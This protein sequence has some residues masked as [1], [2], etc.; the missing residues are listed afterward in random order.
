MSNRA[1]IAVALCAASLLAGCGDGS[2]G[3]TP[4]AS[5]PAPRPSA[6]AATARARPLLYVW[7]NFEET[8]VPDEVTVYADGAIRYRY[9]LHTQKAINVQ[10]A[11]LP[12]QGLA[13]VRGLLR[14]IDLRRAD[15]SNVKP[16]RSGYRYVIRS[17]GRVGTAAD[18]HLAG[19]L[20]GLLLRVDRVMDR[21]QERSL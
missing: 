16:R 12:P 5:S 20:R 18:G 3:A 2:T 10:S 6:T 21:L 9:L 14:R 13:A 17:R 15:A 1:G 11:R 8:G 4:A 7:R 19:P